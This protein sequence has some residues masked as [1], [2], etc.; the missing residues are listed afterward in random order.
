[1][2]ITKHLCLFA[3]TFSLIFNLNAEES[4][5]EWVPG[6]QWE[7][8]IS[9][10]FTK[11]KY[12][13]FL[14]QLNT[15]YEIGKETNEWQG[16]LQ[17]VDTFLQSSEFA[18]NAKQTMSGFQIE[19]EE[20]NKNTETQLLEVANNSPGLPLSEIIISMV[21]ANDSTPEEKEAARFMA[22]L[23]YPISEEN[24]E[25]LIKLQEIAKEFFIKHSVLHMEGKRTYDTPCWTD[26]IDQKAF[27]EY[28]V[29]L[30][31]SSMQKMFVAA[32][33][34]E[35]INAKLEKA[36]SSYRKHIA[37]SHDWKY[38]ES[39]G[40]QKCLPKNPTEEQVAA[41]MQKFLS[42]KKALIQKFYFQQ[43]GGCK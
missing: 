9:E 16:M 36:L 4:C 17:A 23:C 13:F 41:I 40:Q 15:R 39:L 21:H 28:V 20:L 2:K 38:L 10:A 35:V 37:K 1:M 6:A 22:N 24:N 8:Q 30:K 33:K 18:E 43:I 42:E 26:C 32:Q 34:D 25:V 31:L 19:I 29:A 12:D 5:Q 11:G 7:K 27:Q 3:F 14:Q